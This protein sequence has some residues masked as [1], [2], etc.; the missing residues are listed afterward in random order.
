[1]KAKKGNLKKEIIKEGLDAFGLILILSA[2]V[3]IYIVLAI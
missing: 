2:F 1:M 3:S